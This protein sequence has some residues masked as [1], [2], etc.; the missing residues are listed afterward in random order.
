MPD[1]PSAQA[2]FLKALFHAAG[3]NPISY[4][5]GFERISSC[6]W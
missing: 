1:H 4:Q 2:V 5:A 6:L 3:H